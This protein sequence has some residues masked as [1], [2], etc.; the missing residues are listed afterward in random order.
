MVTLKGLLETR[1]NF[2]I[3]LK[4]QK[5]TFTWNGFSIIKRTPLHTVQANNKT[6]SLDIM[7][8]NKAN[9]T[10]TSEHRLTILKNGN[11]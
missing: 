8:A 9:R 1:G 5:D 2:W 10:P 3:E 6:T 11:H 4:A 7:F